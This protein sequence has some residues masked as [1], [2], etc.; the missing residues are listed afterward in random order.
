MRF[1]CFFVL[2]A[3]HRVIQSPVCSGHSRT[4]WH[5]H[6]TSQRY[7]FLP[8]LATSIN[9]Y[10]RL[11]I[12]VCA[13]TCVFCQS[14]QNTPTPNFSACISSLPGYVNQRLQTPLHHRLRT[15]RS[16]QNTP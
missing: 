15:D 10:K 12:I 7:P 11:S 8:Y 4:H 6:Q 13:L 2:E 5:P 1:S 14:S 9:G 3:S 16:S